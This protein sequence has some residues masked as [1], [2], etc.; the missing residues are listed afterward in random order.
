MPRATRRPILR[1]AA[2]T[3]LERCG[4]FK[5][6]FQQRRGLRVLC[7][8]GVCADDEAGAP[9]V[10][11]TFVTAGAF[12]AQLD[13][14]RR[15]GPAVTV[16][17][18]LA[19]GP[20]APAESA[21]AITFDD[22]AACA[23]EHARPALARRGV[24][25]SWYVATGHVTSG[26]LFDGDVVRL[27]RTYPELVSPAAREAVDRMVGRRGGHKQCSIDELRAALGPAEAELRARLPARAYAALRA[28]SWEQVT[29]L[30]AEGHEIG[31]HTVDH[32]ILAVQTAAE[33]DRQVDECVSALRQRLGRAVLGFAY[34][35]GGPG[36]FGPGDQ[37]RLAA[38]GVRYAVTTRCGDAD[39]GHPYALNRVC[40]GG[41]HSPASFALELSGWLDRRRLMQQ[42]WL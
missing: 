7:Y 21:W 4:V 26:R 6:A 2:L 23:F 19:A 15:Y 5:R 16:A 35:N 1:E 9:W 32:A 37:Q 30:A 36:D 38:A 42:G 41:R 31:G 20:D 39:R 17:E 11:G 14:L 12:A 29:A 28:V 10:P 3:A 24:R 27:V 13:V 40:I 25:A 8:H 34:P 18:W 33:R 22:V